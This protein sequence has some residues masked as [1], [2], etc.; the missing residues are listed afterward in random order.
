[1]VITRHDWRTNGDLLEWLATEYPGLP[2]EGYEA[3]YR[4]LS[5]PDL[6]DEVGQAT[7]E[8]LQLCIPVQDA[9]SGATLADTATGGGSPT[10]PPSGADTA[11]GGDRASVEKKE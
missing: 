8:L 5:D 1:M 3:A 7:E 9:T 2:P 10:E 6:S 4:L 11:T